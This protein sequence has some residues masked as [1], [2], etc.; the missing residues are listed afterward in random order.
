[1]TSWFIQECHTHST[2]VRTHDY[3]QTNAAAATTEIQL[4]ALSRSVN[5]KVDATVFKS[6][7]VQSICQYRCQPL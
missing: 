4:T 3:D 1:M 6:V 5:L 7:A 2:G